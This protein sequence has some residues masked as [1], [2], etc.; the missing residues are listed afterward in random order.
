M[1]RLGRAL[2]PN[3]LLLKIEQET[4]RDSDDR[5]SESNR[6]HRV[7]QSLNAHRI[8]ILRVIIE[9]MFWTVGVNVRL[10]FDILLT[11]RRQWLGLRYPLCYNMITHCFPRFLS[12]KEHVLACC[13][14][15]AVSPRPLALELVENYR[16][17]FNFAGEGSLTST[18]LCPLIHSGTMTALIN[19]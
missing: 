15:R 16:Q 13:R 11:E 5:S 17:L 12:R 3:L 9:R 2:A 1:I 4:Y 6:C 14:S 18:P 10:S 19:S 8:V 7:I